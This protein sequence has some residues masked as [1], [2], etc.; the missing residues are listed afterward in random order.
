METIKKKKYEIPITD[1]I[2]L[3]VEGTILT[4]SGDA[5]QYSGPYDF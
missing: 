3:R 2:E 4:T 1:V 5:P